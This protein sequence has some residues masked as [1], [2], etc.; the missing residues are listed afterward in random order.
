MGLIL[1]INAGAININDEAGLNR[2]TVVNTECWMF[3]AN[4]LS[5]VAQS[6]ETWMFDASWLDQATEE[7]TVETWMFNDNYL[8]IET[9]AVE[10]W[11]LDSGYLNQ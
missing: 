9:P 6:M 10:P 5:G 3:D 7:S 8:D 2:E 4:Y 1:S 11:M